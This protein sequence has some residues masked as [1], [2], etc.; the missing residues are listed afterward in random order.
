MIV[1]ARNWA[2]GH[3]LVTLVLMTVVVMLPAI[4]AVASNLFVDWHP[5]GD[6]SLAELMMRG[7]P[8]NPP[9]VGVAARVGRDINDQGYKPGPSMAYALY[10][11]Y[12]AMFRSS[13]S[14]IVSTLVVHMA[15]VLATLFFV[16]RWFGWRYT[17]CDIPSRYSHLW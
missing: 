14:V 3:P 16:R 11:V 1:R 12:L 2:L 4:V 9:L 13:I 17:A 6:M 7:I 15:G 8:D 10:P 5:T